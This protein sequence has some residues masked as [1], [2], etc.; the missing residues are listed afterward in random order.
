MI[1][2]PVQKAKEL[3]KMARA[4]LDAGME[5]STPYSICFHAQQC[6]EKYLKAYLAYHN[7]T[8]PRTHDINHLIESCSKID[9]SLR[10]LSGSAKILQPYAVDIRYISSK[11]KAEQECPFVWKAMQAVYNTIREKLPQSMFAEEL[12]NR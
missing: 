3:I 11:Q 8:I 9:P 1:T 4:D 7:A 10:S 2:D 6:A 12:D 5:S